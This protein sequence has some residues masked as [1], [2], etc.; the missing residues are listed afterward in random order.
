[1]FS[2]GIKRDQGRKAIHSAKRCFLAYILNLENQDSVNLN[3]KT[4]DCVK[5]RNI[6]IFVVAFFRS[7]MLVMSLK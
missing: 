3:L 7:G 6:V 1:M 5:C 4:K 2:G